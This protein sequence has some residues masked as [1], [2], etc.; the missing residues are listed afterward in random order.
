MMDP[1]TW[2]IGWDWRPTFLNN[3]WE[4]FTGVTISKSPP[5]CL[6]K[7]TMFWMKW[8]LIGDLLHTPF[9]SPFTSMV[10]SWQIWLEMAWSFLLLRD[11]QL[12]TCLQEARLSRPIPSVFVLLHLLLILLA[13]GHLF[14]R[15]QLKLWSKR[16][17]TIETQPGYLSTEPPVS[18]YKMRKTLWL[19]PLHRP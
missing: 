2:T 10:I 8:W 16:S 15:L 1:F 4:K 12:T 19:K 6:C 7:I 11:P 5:K 13:S 3:P 18:C 17:K 9:S 14:S